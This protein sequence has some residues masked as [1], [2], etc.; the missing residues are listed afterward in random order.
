MEA[1]EGFAGVYD[2]FMEETDY[3]QWVEHIEEIWKRYGLTPK[4]CLD[5]GCGTGNVTTRLADRGISMIGIDLSEEMLVAAREKAEAQGQDILYLHQDMRE[6]ELYGTVNS[7]VCLCD[8]LNYITEEEE[9]LQVFS[10][11]N[12]YL[13][14]G[15]LFLFDMNTEYKFREVL[16]QNT[17]AE[18]LENA[19]YIW[20]N[21][22]D[23]E[24]GINAYYMNFF[25]ENPI[26]SGIYERREEIHYEKG[27]S[28]E[29]IRR[30]LTKSGLKVL[31][32]YDG[33][34][35]NPPGQDT[36]RIFVVAQEVMKTEVCDIFQ[37]EMNHE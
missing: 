35:F 23:E 2:Q 24:T 8:S 10:L 18:A 33:Y 36:Q 37:E 25:V 21:D 13:H 14:P 17:F 27:Y 32:I 34:T 12:N 19:A 28:L 3:D 30:L 11:V 20:E 4:L 6:F 29:T 26:G 16:G 15:G 7:V 9:L 22:Y 1:Y 5:L 31:D